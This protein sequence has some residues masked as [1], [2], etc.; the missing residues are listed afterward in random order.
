M[1]PNFNVFG[2]FQCDILTSVSKMNYLPLYQ[3]VEDSIAEN[4][5]NQFMP[6]VAQKGLALVI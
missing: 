4:T 5:F 3:R 2:Q 6:T 1:I